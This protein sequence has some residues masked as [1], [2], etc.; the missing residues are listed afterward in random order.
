MTSPLPRPTAA[1][2]RRSLILG[3]AGLAGTAGLLAACG[4]DD[5]GGTA[6][7]DG[8]STGT[9]DSASSGYVI[10]P[11]FPNSKVLTPGNLRLAFSISDVDGA[12]L[13]DGPETI[14][15]DLVDQ[16]NAVLAPIEA[17]R[18]GT[19]LSVPY[20]SV[21]ASTASASTAP[22]AIRRRS[23]SSTPARRPS[24]SRRSRCHRSTRR[25][26]TTPAASTRSARAQTGH[27][28]STT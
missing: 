4:S 7:T 13:L 8:A 23:S 12:L 11:R 22:R 21:R 5:D 20:W 28:R 1:L 10:N 15:G 25:R 3:A 16:N 9:G 2:S 14:A 26:S 18:R 24:P 6:S 19:G 17:T 27:A